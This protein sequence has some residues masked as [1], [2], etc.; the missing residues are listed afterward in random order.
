M[1]LT[2][3]PQRFHV[4]Q[5]C[6][7]DH[8]LENPILPS[9]IHWPTGP[10]LLVAHVSYPKTEEQIWK[11]GRRIINSNLTI[12]IPGLQEYVYLCKYQPSITGLHF[13]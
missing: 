13:N 1:I 8:G 5:V 4:L 6:T 11:C 2:A 12:G 3:L 9:Q 10:V 7:Q